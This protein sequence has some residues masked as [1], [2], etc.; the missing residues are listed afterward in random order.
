MFSP[1]LTRS[2]AVGA[3][4]IAVGGGAYG[5]VSGTSGG[6]SGSDTASA[7]TTAKVIPFQ[8]GQ[9]TPSRVVGQVPQGWSPGSGTL[10]TG[11]AA[12]TAKAAALAAYP[13]GTVNRVVRVGT[14]TTTST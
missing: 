6:G 11:T 12:N 9:P 3:A 2:I 8:R 7:A 13:G 1:K 5:I 10:V 14:A 4:A